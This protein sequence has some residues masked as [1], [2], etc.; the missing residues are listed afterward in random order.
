MQLSKG[1]AWKLILNHKI[2]SFCVNP[3]LSLTL[4]AANLSLD[5]RTER[6]SAQKG[7]NFM[8]QADLS[9]NSVASAMPVPRR[10]PRAVGLGFAALISAALWAGLF[11]VFRALF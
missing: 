3:I 10:L 8:S 9:L 7:Q 11:E 1:V 2:Q 4:R 6:S 5:S